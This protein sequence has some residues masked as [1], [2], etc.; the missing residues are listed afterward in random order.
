MNQVF[1]TPRGEYIVIST[2]VLNNKLVDCTLDIY[3]KKEVDNKIVLQRILLLPLC[4]TKQD[5]ISILTKEKTES[6]K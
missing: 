4:L 5:P 3:E 6:Q 2:P 1:H